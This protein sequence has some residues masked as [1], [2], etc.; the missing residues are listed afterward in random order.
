MSTPASH[1][2]KRRAKGRLRSE[3]HQRRNVGNARQVVADEGNA[4]AGRRRP[5]FNADVLAAP[6]P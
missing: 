6:E 4:G 2:L 1:A 3:I 5:K